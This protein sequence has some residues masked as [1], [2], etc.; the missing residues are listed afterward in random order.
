MTPQVLRNL[1]VGIGHC[2]IAYSSVLRGISKLQLNEAA[3]DKDLDNS[4]EVGPAVFPWLFV[5][6]PFA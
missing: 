3:L 5:L 4:W 1:G 6:R 2:L